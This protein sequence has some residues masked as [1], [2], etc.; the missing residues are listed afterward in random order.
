M[1]VDELAWMDEGNCR[2]VDPDLFFPERGQPTTE[3]KAICQGC[4]VRDECLEHALVN[5][6]RWGI[7]GGKSERE[8]RRIR[9]D[10]RRTHNGVEPPPSGWGPV[11]RRHRHTLGWSQRTLARA[12]GVS[13]GVVDKI[14]AGAR[15]PSPDTLQRLADAIGVT[16]DELA[17]ALE[18]SA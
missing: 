17:E 11:I 8:R 9:R 3:P 15:N 6:E 13:R 4:V 14:E 16:V 10:R 5:G 1:S 7:W 2:G 18:V 12:A